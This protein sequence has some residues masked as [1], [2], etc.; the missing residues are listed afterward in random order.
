MNHTVYILHSQKLK[1][2]YTGYASNLLKRL[3][4]HKNA[5]A[6]KFTYNSDDWINVFTINCSSKTQGLSIEKH[7][8][9]MKSKIYNQVSGNLILEKIRY[10]KGKSNC[11][12]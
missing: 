11:P 9:K 1:K 12:Y 2:F 10:T 3:D 4:F 8:K 5:E 7:I 6:R